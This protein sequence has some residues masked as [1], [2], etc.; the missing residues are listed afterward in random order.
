MIEGS[1]GKYLAVYNLVR[2]S[3]DKVAQLKEIIERKQIENEL[4]ENL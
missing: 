1:Q 2:E 3:E 4:S